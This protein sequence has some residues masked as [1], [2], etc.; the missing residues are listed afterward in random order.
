MKNRCPVRAAAS[1]SSSTP[2]RDALAVRAVDARG[3]REASRVVAGPR[4]GPGLAASIVERRQR[5]D[6]RG[7]RGRAPRPLPRV[8]PASSRRRGV[9]RLVRLSA[10]HTPSGGLR[11]AVR[12]PVERRSG[13]ARLRVRAKDVSATVPRRLRD[14]GAAASPRSVAAA[15]SQRRCEGVPVSRGVDLHTLAHVNVKRRAINGEGGGT[16]TRS[17]GASSDDDIA[18]AREAAP[19]FRFRSAESRRKSGRRTEGGGKGRRA[20]AVLS[21]GVCRLRRASAVI[22]LAGTSARLGF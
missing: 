10:R 2:G 19:Q 8:G 5:D 11:S 13:V 9:A 15:A 7:A 1:S 12:V 4:P 6:G 14:D 21:P 17:A 18:V 16:S 20:A 3:K 22:S